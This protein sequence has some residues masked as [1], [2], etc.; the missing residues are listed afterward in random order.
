MPT[1]TQVRIESP[2]PGLRPFRESESANFFGQDDQIEALL[3]RL[4][5]T[6]FVAVM[7]SSGCGKSS[8]VRAGLVATLRQGATGKPHWYIAT[9]RPGADPLGNLAAALQSALPGGRDVL[10]CLRRSARGIVDAVGAAGIDP[11]QRVL[12]V[13]DQFEELFRYRRVDGSMK[14]EDDTALFVRLLLEAAADTCANLYVV[15]TMRLDFFSDCAIFYGLAERINDGLYLLPKM[16]RR[17]LRE[18]IEGPVH[19][20]GATISP[21]L[22]ER[23]LIESEEREDG[24]PL[25]QHALMRIW[26]RWVARG[27]FDTPIGEE[28]FD[29]HDSGCTRPIIECQLDTHLGAIYNSLSPERQHCAARLFKLLSE[30]DHG[31][32]VRRGLPL[33]EISR[34]L[35]VDPAEL[36]EVI[37]AFRDEPSGRTFLMPRKGEGAPDDPIDIS[38]EVLIRQWNLLREWIQEEA[39][40][41]TLFK[42]IMY[43]AAAAGPGDFLTGTALASLSEWWHRFEPTPEWA[44]RYELSADPGLG[45]ARRSYQSAKA[46]LEVSEAEERRLQDECREEERSRR[47]EELRATFEKATYEAELRAARDQARRQK[48]LVAILNCLMLAIVV[49][50]WQWTA[51]ERAATKE[52]IAN[53]TAAAA[54]TLATDAQTLAAHAT[55]TAAI[56]DESR[57][58]SLDDPA[59]RVYAQVWNAV[60]AEQLNPALEALR[61]G[62]FTVPALATVT[63]G[64]ASTELRFFRVSDRHGAETARS[65]LAGSGLAV[66]VTYV[67]GFE[68]ST[69]MR[70][71]HYELWLGRPE[72]PKGPD[73]KVV[74]LYLSD[75]LKSVADQLGIIVKGALGDNVDVSPYKPSAIT[76]AFDK[77]VE[78]HFFYKEDAPEAEKLKAAL[79]QSDTDL[80]V[81]FMPVSIPVPHRYF[82]IWLQAR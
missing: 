77:P 48:W 4:G 12:V 50:G 62:G 40:D 33:A 38:H 56:L 46:Y 65:L 67:P 19:H 27:A 17:E 35:R 43:P 70:P 53:S 31:R 71:Q 26:Q 15:I 59:P 21:V 74:V 76:W 10:A 41:A 37:D 2:F 24:L 57:R 55:Q 63:V 18:V 28:D 13:V 60:Q 5:E 22:V 8:L 64:P 7:G 58:A 39:R 81:K 52:R 47:E 16:R 82:E 32:E 30:N 49:A 25:L 79:G 11:D 6:R 54:Q 75:S 68:N 80:A 1:D 9:C 61:Q 23:L 78:I 51:A 45:F 20:S 3:D 29:L 69:A 73:A 42:R 66:K 14:R 44:E 34:I 72:P 36:L